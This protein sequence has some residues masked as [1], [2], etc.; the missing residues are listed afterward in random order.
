MPEFKLPE[1]KTPELFKLPGP[2][3]KVPEFK[4]PEFKVPEFPKPEVPFG[5]PK[6]D[7]FWKTEFK[8]DIEPKPEFINFKQPQNMQMI[9]GYGM[10]YSNQYGSQQNYG[11]GV[12]KGN[13]IFDKVSLKLEKED[14]LKDKFKSDKPLKDPL[15]FQCDEMKNHLI[16]PPTIKSQMKTWC[17]DVDDGKPF[18]IE[19]HEPY[20]LYVNV[21]ES[22]GKGFSVSYQQI[23]CH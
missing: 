17:D 1:L 2:E 19:T 6:F 11:Y 16:F 5:M 13:K 3:F 15:K 22:H 12:D 4:V 20:R 14:L 7:P 10:P 8:P 23:P 21:K 9:Y 18:L